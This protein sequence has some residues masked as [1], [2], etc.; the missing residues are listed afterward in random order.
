MRNVL[1]S[2][3]PRQIAD[4]NNNATL[5]FEKHRL[6]FYNKGEL[7]LLAVCREDNLETESIVT[8]LE[9]ILTGN[10]WGAPHKLTSSQLIDHIVHIHH[11]YIKKQAPAIQEQL[12]KLAIRHGKKQD[13]LPALY[14]AFAAVKSEI[15]MHLRKEELVLFPYIKQLEQ[16]KIERRRWVH[17]PVSMLVEEHEKIKSLLAYIRKSTNDYTPPVNASPIFYDCF[18]ALKAFEQDFYQ[19][20]H[21]ESEFLFPG[22]ISLYEALN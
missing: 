8:E 13:E 5:V 17:L 12:Q 21:L 22:A 4:E 2:K 19:H 18:F 16:G 6:D 3:T 11:A 7:S 10:V 15:N 20:A 14:Y 1:L 9:Q